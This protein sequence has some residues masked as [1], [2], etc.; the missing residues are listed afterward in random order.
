VASAICSSCSGRPLNS[1]SSLPLSAFLVKPSC[2]T[3]GIWV[4]F[5]NCVESL[6]FVDPSKICFCEINRGIDAILKM[7]RSSLDIQIE[8]RWYVGSCCNETLVHGKT[9]NVLLAVTFSLTS[10]ALRHYAR[11]EAL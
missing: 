9:S 4:D 2:Y 1:P 11:H 3:Q 6:G 5:Q 10:N 7:L 8:K